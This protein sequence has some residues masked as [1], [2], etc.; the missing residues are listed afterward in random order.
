[1]QLVLSLAVIARMAAA[2]P[3]PEPP[4]PQPAE[5]PSVVATEVTKAS[6][7]PAKAKLG[8]TPHVTSTATLSD[9]KDGRL[10]RYGVTIGAGV[11]LQMVHSDKTDSTPAASPMVY[12]E[13]MPFL[14]GAV[15]GHISRAFCVAQLTEG[16][17]AQAVADNVA[18]N[19]IGIDS[20]E[21]DDLSSLGIDNLKAIAD[22]VYGT[23]IAA[24]S[25]APLPGF[26][27]AEDV[28]FVK[29]LRD[30]YSVENGGV[31][32]LRRPEAAGCTDTVAGKAR[33]KFCEALTVLNATQAPTNG[34][35]PP[36]APTARETNYYRIQLVL[37]ALDLVLA[38]E[39]A[40]LRQQSPT[41][42]DVST[43][44]SYNRK[45]KYLHVVKMLVHERTGWSLGTPADG[46][47]SRVV[48]LYVGLPGKFTANSAIGGGNM[49]SRVVTEFKPIASV[50]LAFNITSFIQLTT[51]VTFSTT[52]DVNGANT[53]VMSYTVGLGGSLDILGMLFGK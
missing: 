2:Q 42:A 9:I 32:T 49:G 41:G 30:R 12:V 35:A 36:A 18:L 22:A 47:K 8:D 46:C 38:E 29:Q 27:T 24:P 10:S 5:V 17:T 19:S 23:T 11:A 20:A 33:P 43:I 31:R 50:G 26:V 4:K 13:V 15:R 1:L 39:N 16:K 6:D 51:G 25:N 28:A 3:A 14:L 37:A 53:T 34:E 45:Q 44:Q 21:L 40:A 52:P 7:A 48:G